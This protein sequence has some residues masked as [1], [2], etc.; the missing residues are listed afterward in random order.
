MVC[1][2]SVES[3]KELNDRRDTLDAALSECMLCRRSNGG[4][5]VIERSKQKWGEAARSG[6]AKTLDG[7]SSHQGVTISEEPLSFASVAGEQHEQ[8]CGPNAMGP[9]A[10]E[11][12]SPNLVGEP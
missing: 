5:L 6:F 4:A 12:P 9:T 11:R 2:A 1:L 8:V 7:A 3:F 10:P